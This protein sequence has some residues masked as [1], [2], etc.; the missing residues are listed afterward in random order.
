MQRLAGGH[1]EGV[2]RLTCANNFLVLNEEEKKQVGAVLS[3]NVL[4]GHI[5]SI[6]PWPSY[7]KLGIPRLLLSDRKAIPSAIG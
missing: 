5:S 4:P 1:E 6:Q 3:N 2:S 7:K